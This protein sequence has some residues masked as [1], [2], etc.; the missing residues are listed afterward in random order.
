MMSFDDILSET[1]D[2]VV[3]NVFE[4]EI[5]KIVL[6]YLKKNSSKNPNKRVRILADAL[7]KVLGESSVIVEDL[8]LE[9]LYSKC[10][11]ELKWKRSYR[12]A[13]YILDLMDRHNSNSIACPSVSRK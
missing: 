9:T 13:D 2:E 6:K 7:P 8:I 3:N 10:G 11:L 12:F 4:K 1:I 5:A